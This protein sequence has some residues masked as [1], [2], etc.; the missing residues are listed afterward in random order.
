VVGLARH[1]KPTKVSHYKLRTT[2]KNL[3]FSLRKWRN[4]KVA[5]THLVDSSLIFMM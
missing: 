2:D 4:L 5:A 3:W 1:P